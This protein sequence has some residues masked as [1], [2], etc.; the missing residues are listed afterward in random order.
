MS[1]KTV[2]IH[3]DPSS[4]PWA[5]KLPAVL[6][7]LVCMYLPVPLAQLLLVFCVLL[8]MI[9]LKDT[10]HLFEIIPFLNGMSSH[11]LQYKTEITSLIAVDLPQER[12]VEPH[13]FAMSVQNRTRLQ[14]CQRVRVQLFFLQLCG[15]NQKFHEVFFFCPFLDFGWYLDIHT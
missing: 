1:G 15:Q 7:L 4:T 9:I 6:L 5:A 11:S 12:A 14:G 13:L 3:Y 8:G 10:M 2:A